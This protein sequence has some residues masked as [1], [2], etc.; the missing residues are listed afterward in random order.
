MNT[1]WWILKY[2]EGGG[3]DCNVELYDQVVKVG[4]RLG[5]LGASAPYYLPMF[6]E[7]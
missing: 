4:E 7:R 2:E 6:V 1:F 5:R 3:Q